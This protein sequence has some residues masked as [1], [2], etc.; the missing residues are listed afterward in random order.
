M[1]EDDCFTCGARSRHQRMIERRCP[2]CNDIFRVKSDKNKKIYCT[3]E[4]YLENYNQ[5]RRR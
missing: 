4:C 1:D 2:Q 5:K 3:R